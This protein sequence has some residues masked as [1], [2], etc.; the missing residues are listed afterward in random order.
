MPSYDLYRN[1]LGEQTTGKARHL[2]SEDIIDYTWWNDFSSQVAYLYDWYHDLKSADSHKLRDLHPCEDPQKIPID[3]KYL[4]NGSQTYSK[5]IITYHIQL[6]PHQEC[7][8]DY[9]DAMFGRYDAIFPVGLYIDIQDNKGKYNRWLVVGTANF[10]DPMFSTYEILPCDKLLQWIFDGK[11][12]NMAGVLRS[13]NSYN[14]GVWTDY[15]VTSIEDQQKFIV[16]INQESQNLFYN[17]RMI[18]D[19]KVD[20]E[21]RAWVISKVNRIANNGLV[22]CTLAQDR[23]DQNHDFIE[24]SSDGKIIGMWA[25]YFSDGIEPKEDSKSQ[26]VQ[27]SIC[28]SG[29]Q[30]NQLKIGGNY[31]TFYVKFYDIEGNQQEAQEGSW[32]FS[33]NGSDASSL[34]SV[35]DSD[36]KN[37]I[38]I[39]FIGDDTY[40]GEK[41]VISFT[42]KDNLST[43]L[44]M[45]LSAL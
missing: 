2:Q 17:Q 31:R 13:Q 20:A 30:N 3:I 29:V 41:L 12:H 40:I 27:M 22:Q 18:I 10:Y 43:S 21:P 8:V 7:N 25:D 35:V 6:R 33:I 4:A 24:R 26:D 38:K 14:S 34:L 19:N 9:Y 23:Y 1:I 16:P 28:Y 5:D 39:K 37:N 15:K 32:N 36:L 11:K 44:E 42:I 45:N